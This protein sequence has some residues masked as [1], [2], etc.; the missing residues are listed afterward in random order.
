MQANGGR[1][2]FAAIPWHIECVGRCLCVGAC[3]CIVLAAR[4]HAA[5]SLCNC[6]KRPTRWVLNP[7]LAV[8]LPPACI[9]VAPVL[10]VHQCNVCFAPGADLLAC[11]LWQLVLRVL[12]GFCCLQRSACQ[13][14]MAALGRVL[15]FVVEVQMWLC[16]WYK[17]FCCCFSCTRL[18]C[19]CGSTTS[20]GLQWVHLLQHLVTSCLLGSL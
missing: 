19:P 5:G 18:P 8:L 17:A 13:Q 15:I 16:T 12:A 11:L 10:P 4:Y 1:R 20:S 2:S 6:S 3:I 7:T 14:C 9:G